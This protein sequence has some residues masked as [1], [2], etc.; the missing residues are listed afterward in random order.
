[1]RAIAVPVLLSVNM[2]PGDPTRSGCQFALGSR[3]LNKEK[4]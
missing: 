1:M 4:V 2:P 3:S